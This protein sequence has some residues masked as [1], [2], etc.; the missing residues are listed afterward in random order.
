MEITLGYDINRI[1]SRKPNFGAHYAANLV[2]ALVSVD[3]CLELVLYSNQKKSALSK[4]KDILGHPEV[5]FRNYISPKRLFTDKKLDVFHG[6]G[7]FR[8]DS[9]RFKRVISLTDFSVFKVSSFGENDQQN[10]ANKYIDS[11]KHYEKIVCPS[12]SAAKL[13]VEYMP[14]RA[15]DIVVIEPGLDFEY[16]K[17]PDEKSIAR[18]KEELGIAEDFFLYIGKMEIGRNIPVMIKGY[19]EYWRRSQSVP[20]L[21]MVTDGNESAAE[22]LL[23]GTELLRSK[24]KLITTGNL[25]DEQLLN[26]YSSAN[27]LIH[28][29][30]TD[31]YSPQV[32]EAMAMGVPVL[33][34]AIGF[35]AE[36]EHD[37]ARFIDPGDRDDIC[38]ALDAVENNTQ[39]R[40]KLIEGGKRFTA[41]Y[42]WPNAASAV[43]ELYS[44]LLK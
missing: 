40:N 36:L 32:I 21:V 31:F 43:L 37:S 1:F 41:R 3:D 13:I 14:D 2:K 5:K 7:D 22:S 23:S 11:L 15:N 18:T 26:L 17:L 20:S 34:S 30:A 8:P 42:R 12:K 33:C 25:S 10:R 28:P 24:G 27:A 6:F 9:K 4:F 39:Y 44:N 29:V 38:N 35:G 19:I 16:K